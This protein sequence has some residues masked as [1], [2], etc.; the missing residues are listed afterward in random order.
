MSVPR[1]PYCNHFTGQR[2]SDGVE[3]VQFTVHVCD[4][5]YRS[6]R[7]VGPYHDE[8]G[9][10]SRR[11]PGDPT[12]PCGWSAFALLQ[13]GRIITPTSTGPRTIWLD[14]SRTKTLLREAVG[15]LLRG[16]PGAPRPRGNFH[17][18]KGELKC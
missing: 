13:D 5:T 7:G 1:C 17:P 10:P 6:T 15:K 3:E 12:K 16:E 11:P 14:L 18:K 9:Q 4:V 8:Q 2:G